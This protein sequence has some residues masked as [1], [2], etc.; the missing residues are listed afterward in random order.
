MLKK[1]KRCIIDFNQSQY[2]QSI[3]L[4][5]LKLP[6]LEAG[7]FEYYDEEDESQANGQTPKQQPTV[8]TFGT[9][10]FDKQPEPLAQKQAQ[11][12]AAGEQFEYYDEE[13]DNDPKPV[14]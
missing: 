14:L 5:K 9:V 2:F 12:P 11:P 4:K 13:D 3:G 8:P 1:L 7:D 6:K 10:E